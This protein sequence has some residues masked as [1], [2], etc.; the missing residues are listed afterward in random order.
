MDNK[1]FVYQEEDRVVRIP[2]VGF[3]DSAQEA[4]SK[5]FEDCVP[6]EIK[7]SNIWNEKDPKY[8]VIKGQSAFDESQTFYAEIV[9]R[10]LQQQ[11]NYTLGIL[12][13]FEYFNTTTSKIMMEALRSIASNNPQKNLYIW[14][15]VSDADDYQSVK[16]IKN[17]VV[18][19]K[20]NIYFTIDDVSIKE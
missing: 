7:M 18:D 3:T 8:I 17:I 19:K 15:L 10:L 20:E 16:H 14:W 6:K 5:L 4:L 2:F 12:I 1:W 11:K 13:Y 9:R